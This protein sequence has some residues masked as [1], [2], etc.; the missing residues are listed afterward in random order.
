MKLR[1]IAVLASALILALNGYGQDQEEDTELRLTRLEALAGRIKLGGWLDFAYADND[2][3]GQQD[4]FNV[5]H[6]YL[7][8]DISINQHWLAFVE[9]EYENLPETGTS[10]E[11]DGR[12]ILDRGYIEYRYH[13]GARFQMGKFSTPAGIWKPEH[14]AVTTDA[15]LEPIMEQLEFI[16]DKSVGLQ[17]LGTRE[18]PSGS[19]EYAVIFTNGA[20]ASN[21]R[22]RNGADGLGGDVSFRFPKRGMLGFSYHRLE[23]DRDELETSEYGWMLY[24][25]L[26]IVP[27]KLMARSEFLSYEKPDNANARTG[28]VKLKWSFHERLYANIRFD[29]AAFE[30]HEEGVDRQ[31]TEALTLGYWPHP[32]VRIKAEMARTHYDGSTLDDFRE[33]SAWIGLTF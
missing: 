1:K 24:G 20:E 14:W 27:Q 30:G 11:D 9:I 13:A 22:G 28:Y 16:P 2:I 29:Y 5:Q 15:T 7:N 18:T 3:K 26:N 12:I 25:E 17:F 23:D 19:L 4:F 33:W 32:R 31:Q 6:V 8:F 10:E 21:T